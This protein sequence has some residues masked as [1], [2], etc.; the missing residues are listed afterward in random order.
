MTT[1]KKSRQRKQIDTLLGNLLE[2]VCSLSSKE[3]Q[4]LDREVAALSHTNCWW[5][6]Y[7]AR[8]LLQTAINE[9]GEQLKAKE[10]KANLP[11]TPGGE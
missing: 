6:T 11:D 2:Y 7:Q 3:L 9:A 5:F 10:A 4:A 8:F 1:K